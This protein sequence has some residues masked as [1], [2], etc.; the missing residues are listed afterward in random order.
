MGL[1]EPK[2][3][4]S[5]KNSLDRIGLSG[6]DYSTPLNR[7]ELNNVVRCATR[8]LL[9]SL[10]TTGGRPSRPSWSFVVLIF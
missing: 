10:N 2:L 6:K 4:A 9:K 8:L 3:Q 5:G 7:I 1:I